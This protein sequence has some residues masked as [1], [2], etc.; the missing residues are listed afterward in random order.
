MNQQQYWKKSTY[1]GEKYSSLAYRFKDKD[2]LDKVLLQSKHTS[3]CEEIE[4]L[5]FKL[6]KRTL[7]YY[8]PR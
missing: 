4:K 6:I 8:K 7:K 5:V 3:V 2:L 1:N